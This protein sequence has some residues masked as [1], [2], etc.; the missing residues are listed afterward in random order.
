MKEFKVLCASFVYPRL[1]KF[2]PIFSIK[3]VSL[4]PLKVILNH[5]SLNVQ[6]R[7]L[8]MLFQIQV[9]YEAPFGRAVYPVLFPL[10]DLLSATSDYV[11]CF[12]IKKMKAKGRCI[13]TCSRSSE[14]TSSLSMRVRLN[15]PSF[16]TVDALVWKLR[17]N[18]LGHG[19]SWGITFQQ[20]SATRLTGERFGSQIKS[21]FLYQ[22]SLQSRLSFKP[23]SRHFYEGFGF[24]FLAGDRTCDLDEV[25]SRK[26]VYSLQ[27]EKKK[28]TFK[29]A[30]MYLFMTKKS[31]CPPYRETRVVTLL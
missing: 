6:F 28:K 19:R 20:V 18:S 15:Q 30:Q 14:T 21:A 2:Q 5:M 16:G 26:F 10:W 7:V 4:H 3:E 9:C 11:I 31:V 22:V 27:N 25:K 8:F 13:P 1:N 29:A 23:I 24:L 17:A 12:R